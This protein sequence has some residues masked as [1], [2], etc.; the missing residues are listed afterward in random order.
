MLDAA[1]AAARGLMG[2]QLTALDATFLELEEADQSAHMHIGGVMLLEPSRAAAPRR[3]SR[4]ARTSIARLPD[5]PRYTPAAL[6]TRARAACTGRAGS[7]DRASTSSA[8]S[9]RPACPRRAARDELLEWAGEYYSQRLDRTKPLW[10]IVVLELADGRWAMVTKTH[11]CMIDGVGSVDI[12][13][14][15][16]RHRARERPTARQ[17]QLERRGRPRPARDD[18][19]GAR[20]HGLARGVAR[21][22]QPGLR[23]R[24]RGRARGARPALHAAESAVGVAAHPSRARDAF[25]R[26]RRSR[27]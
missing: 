16:A 3:S 9:S 21:L 15:A 14:D 12:G 17:R 13:D 6:R 7:E 25:R 27:S 18:R 2:E 5:L 26:S 10:E 24:A 11:H 4:S 23:A 1:R 19:R 20:A 22:A 8:T